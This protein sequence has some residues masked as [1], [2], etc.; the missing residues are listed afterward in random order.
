MYTVKSDTYFSCMYDTSATV[1][2]LN[3]YIMSEWSMLKNYYI[4][5]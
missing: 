2:P 3:K 4:V 1:F 5:A